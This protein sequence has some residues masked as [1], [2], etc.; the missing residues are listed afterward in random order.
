VVLVEEDLGFLSPAQIKQRI[1]PLIVSHERER[2][3]EMVEELLQNDRGIVRGVDETL[4]K[5]QEGRVRGIIAAKG[6][7]GDARQC[8]RCGRVDRVA[9]RKCPA[10]D[11]ERES[12]S[13]RAALPLLVRRHGVSMEVVSGE[14]ARKLQESGAICGWLREFE[15]KEYSSSASTSS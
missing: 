11:G 7:N 4:A 10:C 2:E 15:A 14:A 6:L 1:A 3:S 9:D 8:T 5:L 13:L 12:V